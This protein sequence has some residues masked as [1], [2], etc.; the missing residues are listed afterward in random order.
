MDVKMATVASTP[1]F[2]VKEC[3]R[4]GPRAEITA[5]LRH[6][7]AEQLSCEIRQRSAKR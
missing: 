4:F 7:Y 6:P 1:P 2:T 5:Q 3:L